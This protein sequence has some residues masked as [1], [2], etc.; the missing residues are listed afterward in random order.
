MIIKNFELCGERRRGDEA[1]GDEAKGDEAMKHI[2]LENV[3]Y[4][5]KSSIFAKN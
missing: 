1:K 4:S 2:S 3:A 5:K